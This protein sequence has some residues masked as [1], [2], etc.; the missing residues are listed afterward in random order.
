MYEE[1]IEV[2]THSRFHEQA[3]K[4]YS[5]LF[6]FKFF[7]QLSKTGR[8][9]RTAKLMQMIC[10][11]TSWHQTQFFSR[12]HL[13]SYFRA[14]FQ[15]PGTTADLL[16]SLSTKTPVRSGDMQTWPVCTYLQIIYPSENSE[17][18]FFETKM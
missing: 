15:Q 3:V 18:C 7:V 10:K 13:P 5:K 12:S 1:K 8:G 14:L 6:E 9:G 4:R 16:G 11:G 2:E 17:M